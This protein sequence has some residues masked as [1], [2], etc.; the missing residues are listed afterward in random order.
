M[1][2]VH[3]MNEKPELSCPSCESKNMVKLISGGTGVIFKGSGFYVTDYKKAAS[4][5]NEKESST[6]GTA[7][8]EKTHTCTGACSHS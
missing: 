1:E 8:A 4:K 7:T 3:G 5:S 6:A 2:V